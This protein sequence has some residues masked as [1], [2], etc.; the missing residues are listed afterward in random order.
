MNMQ[1]LLFWMI[2]GWIYGIASCIASNGNLENTI[3]IV[4]YFPTLCFFSQFHIYAQFVEIRKKVNKTRFYIFKGIAFIHNKLTMFIDI[5]TSELHE[6][7]RPFI[8]GIL[9]SCMA[10]NDIKIWIKVLS[11]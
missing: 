8:S 6:I 3:V 11:F 2:E 1:S 10:I 4:G 9:P 5:I 7:R